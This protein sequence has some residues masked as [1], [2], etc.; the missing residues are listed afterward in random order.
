[1][2]GTSVATM[3][4]LDLHR[5]FGELPFKCVVPDTVVQEIRDVLHRH[6]SIKPSMY[7]AAVG[8]RPVVT[9]VSPEQ[10][11]AWIRRLEGLIASLNE[12][13]EVVGGQARLDLPEKERERLINNL[14]LGTTDAI[15]TARQRGVPLWTD[16]FPTAVEFCAKV[17]VPRI[18]TQ[19]ALESVGAGFKG[20]V[21]EACRNLFLWGYQ[22]TRLSPRVVV[23]VFRGTKWN[24]K[25]PHSKRMLAYLSSVGTLGTKNCHVSQ[26]LVVEI[27]RECHNRRKA[28]LLVASILDAFARDAAVGAI[29]R[30]LYRLQ[31]PHGKEVRPEF[32][33]LQ[34]ML[35]KWRSA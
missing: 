5:R 1:L 19:V 16:D 31:V 13:C 33:A 3:F 24:P 15:A 11:A 12:H 21:V 2:D 27:W 25:H 14:G 6:R 10:E 9:Q 7:L 28:T 20:T 26:T 8:G 18:W 30:P 17:G 35:R 32:R 34:R 4:L 22:F 29:A 23:D